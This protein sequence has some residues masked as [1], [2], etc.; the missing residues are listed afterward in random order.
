[1]SSFLFLNPWLLAALASLP[2]LWLLLR[3]MPPAPKR[4]FLPSARFLEGL[5]PQTQTPSK[6]PWWILLMRLIIA[7]LIIF[8][9]AQPVINPSQSITGERDLRVVIE[10]GWASA[11]RWNETLRK[12]E[13]IL[14]QAARQDVSVYINTT[15][16]EPSDGKL[17][18]LGPL[19]AGEALSR[20]K[21][22]AP[23][24][25]P[26]DFEALNQ[27][28]KSS[29]QDTDNYY[30]SSGIG[31]R[32]LKDVMDTLGEVNVFTPNIE[33]LPL[34][35]SYDGDENG[36]PQ[37]IIHAPETIAIGT[38]V[39]LQAQGRNGRVLGFENIVI[40]GDE[41][42][43]GI[44]LPDVLKRDLISARLLGRDD[45]AGV[46]L[47]GDQFQKKS[48]GIAALSQEKQAKPFIEA[49]YYLTRALEP[50]ADLKTG[51]I[52]TLLSGN[53]SMI[54]L[55]DI[56]ALSPEQLNN[57]E[58][59][60]SEGGLL[61]RFAGP[62]M[63]QTRQHFLLPTPLRQGARSLEGA[64]TWENP[65]TLQ[66]FSDDAPLAGIEIG[67]EIVIK[68]QLLAEPAQDLSSKTWASL[69]DGTPLITAA[70]RDAGL[71]VMVHTAASP[72]WS[73]LPLSG[74]FVQ[75][76]ERLVDI[77]GT[78]PGDLQDVNGAL[79]PLRVLDGY[80]RLVEPHSNAQ[81]IAAKDVENTDISYQYP[82]GI[83]A[84][85][86]VQ[87]TLNLGDSI[88]TLSA[89]P[90]FGGGVRKRIYDEQY[91]R[92]MLP[93]LL[94]SALAMMLLDWIVMIALSG[95]Y[96][97]QRFKRSA[98]MV[99]L[100]LSFAFAPSA[101]AQ[102]S[103]DIKYA[104]GFYLG[105]I[106][107]ANAGLNAQTRAGL[108][109]LSE[110]LTRRTSAEP[111]GVAALDAETSELSFFPLLY[112]P[113]DASDKP[114]SE[115]ALR[116]VQRY[117]DNGGTILFDTREDVASADPMQGGTNAEAL[118]EMISGLNIPA[119]A[120]IGEDHVLGRSFYL[121]DTFPGRYL[122][123]TIWV[124][125]NSAN[126]RDGVSSVLIGSQD[127]GS[128]WQ[129]YAVQNS[130]RNYRTTGSTRQRELAIRFGINMVMYAL[131]GNY[132]ADQVHMKYII[133]R[134]GQ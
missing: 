95:R 67:E 41:T 121:L 112:W 125:G 47:F 27:T 82:P 62:V 65:P 60:V 48:V 97:L 3:V 42:K 23:Y 44:D 63:E 85:G 103:D 129:S 118:R 50:Y 105:F 32:G 81:M 7:S 106:Q 12:A 37:F 24:S 94:A 64:L 30:L 123:G 78:A 134:L 87:R 66:S 13:D 54:I 83:Y 108:E 49:S 109:A 122:D 55:P 5:V 9:F 92:D 6:T 72:D 53:M 21:G 33:N 73:N 38:P 1:M 28:L 90:D 29:A 110:A 74:V 46:Y 70:Q 88:K 40:R 133:E 8:A 76:L 128:A 117:L 36:N 120:P 101:M 2:A 100:C 58:N 115:A 93:I 18:A 130:G 119:L 22:L 98:A 20:V 84:Q 10:N 75:M 116:N 34:A 89:L 102:N 124:E 56:G 96:N 11:D 71:I 39:T 107:S 31:G 104:D 4:V 77:A 111:D 113:V 59:W 68:Q 86:S 127:W 126:G 35:L 51:D 61:L 99:C 69:D 15:A 19:S 57:L 43:S 45:A 80:G 52:N 91:E 16:A 114:L 26:S 132:K 25:W 17:L 131:T 14:A 79:E